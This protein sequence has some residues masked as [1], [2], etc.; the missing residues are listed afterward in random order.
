MSQ[1]WKHKK[2]GKVFKVTEWWETLP[3]TN[4]TDKDIGEPVPGVPYKFGMLVQVGWL[5]EN[6]GGVWFGVGPTA[7]ESFEVVNDQNP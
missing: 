5:L 2:N 3:D 4:I 6:E 1:T 7:V